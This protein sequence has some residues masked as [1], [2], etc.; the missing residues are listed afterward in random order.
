[1]AVVEGSRYAE[2]AARIADDAV[3]EVDLGI[4]AFLQILEHAGAQLPML[5]PDPL[6]QGDLGVH[7]GRRSQK[8]L[9]EVLPLHRRHAVSCGMCGT[10][11]LVG[12][13]CDATQGACVVHYF[14]EG[15]AQ[16]S[17]HAPELGRPY[18]L[19]PADSPPIGPDTRGTHA[20]KVGLNLG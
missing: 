1:D 9:L 2:L 17:G 8:K 4:T 10:Q 7:V 14:S 13:E 3:Y 15:A 16:G 20:R 18:D 19:R 11:R 5:V 12:Q 6:N